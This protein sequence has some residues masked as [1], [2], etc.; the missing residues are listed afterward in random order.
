MV[1]R[2]SFSQGIHLTTWGLQSSLLAISQHDLSQATSVVLVG[3]TCHS[4]AVYAI[5]RTIVIIYALFSGDNVY[6]NIYVFLQYYFST[7]FNEILFHFVETDDI[8]SIA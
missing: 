6:S 7:Y 8:P 3:Q 2:T 4:P 5:I 1:G